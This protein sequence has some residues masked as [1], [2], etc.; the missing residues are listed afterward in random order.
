[1]GWSLLPAGTLRKRWD[2]LRGCRHPSY[3]SKGQSA[4]HHDLN[5]FSTRE[6]R[7]YKELADQRGI[8]VDFFRYSQRGLDRARKHAGLICTAFLAIVCSVSRKLCPDI[9]NKWVGLSTT[10]LHNLYH[11]HWFSF[12]SRRNRGKLCVPASSRNFHLSMQR[13]TLQIVKETKL[14]LR[15]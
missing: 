13:S 14:L 9:C 10:S 12:H 4:L 11:W 2:V 15:I 3:N 1:M 8:C 5:F 6:P 7:V